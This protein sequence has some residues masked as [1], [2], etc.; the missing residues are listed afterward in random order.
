MVDLDHALSEARRAVAEASRV[1][2]KV[3]KDLE[4]IRSITKDDRSP[5]T[6]A[7]FASQAVIAHRLT[8]ALGPIHLVAEEDSASLREPANAG[9]LAEV[10]EAVRL[11]WPDANT[12]D[13]LSAIDIGNDDGSGRSFWTL[14]PIDGTKGFLRGEQ[15]AVS[16][17]WIDHEHVVLGVLGCPNLSADF[18]RPFDDPDPHGTMYS[19]YGGTGVWEQRADK[20]EDAGVRLR[21]LDSEAGQAVRLCESVEAAH[22][23]HDATAKIMERIAPGGYESVRLDSQCKY[24]VVARGQADAY[25]RMPTKKG[26][27]EKIWDHAAGSIIATEAGCPVSDIFDKGLDFSHG[28]TLET[29][30]GIVCAAPRLHGTIIEAIEALG[31]GAEPVAD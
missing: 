16:L 1:C 26:Y 4:R 11:V 20:P 29:N 2:R 31:L 13:V 17:A 3:Q 5:V 14:D 19:A 9:T 6:I 28:S 10:V 22:S 8:E 24:A 15:Y 7:D 27:R 18:S 23:K 12:D 25:I 30:R 21:L